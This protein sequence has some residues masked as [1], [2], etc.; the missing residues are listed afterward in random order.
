MEP[1][2]PRNNRQLT[3][4]F[5]PLAIQAASQA[6][7]YPLVAMVASRGPGG[8]L[9]LAGLAQSNIVM[10]FLGMFALSYITT[11]M[12][13]ATSREGYQKFRL[14][15]LMTGLAVTAVQAALCI[16]VLAH[17]LFGN[18]IGLPPSIESP[19]KI[20]LLV[21]IP[22]QFLFF[23]RTPYLVIM[24]VGKATGKASIATVGRI[25][26]TAILSPIF[27]LMGL[28]GPIWAVICLTLPVALECL[29]AR[30]FAQPFLRSLEP[31]AGVPPR[32]EEIFFFN[33]PLSIGGY[34]LSA[35][36][37]ILG[38][39][40]ARAPDPE[41]VLPICYLALGLANPV[42][43]AATRIQTVVLAFPP[44]SHKDRLTFRF[45]LGAG[46]VLGLLPLVFILP[47][48]IEI[49]YVKLQ[50][51]MPADMPLVRITAMALICYPFG[52]AIRAQSEGLAAWLKKP[53]TV[54]AGHAVFMVT[55]F[56]CGFLSIF[57]GVPGYV[58][59]AVGL[60]SGSL[61]SSA[62]MRILLNRTKEKA[63]PI[64]PTTTSVG[65]IR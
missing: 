11:G 10:F 47:G 46:A 9:N 50:K 43:F 60:T 39:F 40:I 15:V 1:E 27:C 32:A 8:P 45:T 4:F 18:L 57:L 5:I 25:V 53:T 44:Q 33:L 35:S 51:L 41:R 38:A 19:A 64:A 17:H 62:T 42:A 14:A 58:I 56:V 55:I 13:Y 30:L 6:L 37:I 54:L 65:Q 23:L 49:Y 7:S 59:C 28:V 36:A 16:P 3:R 61:A 2:T 63:I 52:V 12:V 34:F 29:M 31:S 26:L 20:T 48:L 21:S 24:Y 22:L